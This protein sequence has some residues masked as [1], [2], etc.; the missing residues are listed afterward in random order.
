MFLRKGNLP[1]YLTFSKNCFTFIFHRINNQFVFYWEE[2]P[3][4][5]FSSDSDWENKQ[6]ETNHNHNYEHTD[7]K[8][9][10]SN[11]NWN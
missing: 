8:H 11:P 10:C 2:E 6:G 5:Q 9:M 4:S 3:R 1:N 7:Q